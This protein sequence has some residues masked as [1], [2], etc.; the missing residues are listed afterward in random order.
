MEE[1]VRAFM[2]FPEVGK[3]SIELIKQVPCLSHCSF[4]DTYRRALICW[5][6]C[7]KQIGTKF[8]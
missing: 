1:G 6:L 4:I 3:K 8:A 2:S 7:Q 5:R